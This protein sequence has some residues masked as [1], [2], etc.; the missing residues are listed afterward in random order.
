[1]GV[2]ERRG[3]GGEGN[4]HIGL[5]APTGTKRF[6]VWRRLSVFPRAE[7]IAYWLCCLLSVCCHVDRRT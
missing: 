7:S 1:M 5:S 2:A 6:I 4:P 3:I